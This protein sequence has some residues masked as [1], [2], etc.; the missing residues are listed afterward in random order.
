L[1]AHDNSFGRRV[2]FLTAADVTRVLVD[3]CVP[4]TGSCFEGS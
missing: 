3:D 4:G 1:R 2:R